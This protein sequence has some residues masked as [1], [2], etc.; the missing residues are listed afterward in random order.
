MFDPG[1]SM[2]EYDGQLFLLSSGTIFEIPESG[3]NP[4]TPTALVSG[5]SGSSLA[6]GP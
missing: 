2:A 3:S 4:R 6:L 1:S 5:V